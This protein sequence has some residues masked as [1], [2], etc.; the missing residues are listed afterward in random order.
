MPSVSEFGQRHILITGAAGGI[1]MALALQLLSDGARVSALDQDAQG[2]EALRT[3]SGD[4]AQRLLIR[5]VDVSD[6]DAVNAAV[7]AA[8]HA[9]GPVDHL[10]CVA[11]VLQMGRVAELDDTQWSRTMAINMGGV[12]NTCRAVTRGMIERQRGSIVNVSSN[13]ATAPRAA[14]SAYA[15]SKAAVTQ[16]S[17]CLALELAEHGV[18][19]N[20]VSPGSTDTEMQRAMWRLGSSRETVIKGDAKAFRLGIPLRKIATPE[21]I[22][23]AILFL[24]SDRAGHITLHDMRV[25][26]GA[27]LD[28]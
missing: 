26:G 6:S 27:T 24:L 19:C 28:Q 13:A 3:S 12:F 2:L 18:R 22:V 20:T 15:A 17:R 23:E 7:D 14:M 10:A 5:T 1:G 25:D 16:F 21:D 11:G 8:E 9:F 4:A